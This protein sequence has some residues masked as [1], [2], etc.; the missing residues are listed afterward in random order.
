VALL[1]TITLF[2]ML[3]TTTPNK[4]GSSSLNGPS[5]KTIKRLLDY[6]K[7]IRTISLPDG[8]KEIIHSN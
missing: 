7:S 2:S 3:K 5:E 1:I 4:K 6:S 8:K